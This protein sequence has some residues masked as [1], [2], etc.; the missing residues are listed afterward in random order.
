MARAKKYNRFKDWRRDMN[1]NVS[2]GERLT[3]TQVINDLRTT[4]RTDGRLIVKIEDSLDL[5]S[6]ELE[7]GVDREKAEA[8][9]DFVISEIEA[10]WIL[11]HIEKAFSGTAMPV[12]LVRFALSL[13]ELLKAAIEGE[14]EEEL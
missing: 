2:I 4:N 14:K 1:V 7:G 11:D 10:K 12:R 8:R 13:E 3:L 9:R 5:D 6:P